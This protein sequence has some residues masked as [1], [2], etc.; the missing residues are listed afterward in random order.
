MDI[1]ILMLAWA[2]L[3]PLVHEAAHFVAALLCGSRI[4]FEFSWGRLGPVPVPR[5]TWRWPDV[6]GGKIRFICQ[7]GF[8]VE[9]GLIPFLPWTYAAVALFHFAAYPWYAGTDSDFKGMV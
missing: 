3:P 7:A 5:W 4:R 9:L 6:S 1:D 8:L 2:L